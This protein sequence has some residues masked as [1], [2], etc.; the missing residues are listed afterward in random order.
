M[1]EALHDSLSTTLHP[2]APHYIPGFLPDSAGHDPLMTA[3]SVGLVVAFLGIGTLYFRLH[4]LP[5]HMAHGSSPSQ[6]QVVS[7]LALLAL[8]THNNI[9]WVA[10]LLLAA[11]KLPDLLGPLER[12]ASAVEQITGKDQEPQLAQGEPLATRDT[13]EPSEDPGETEEARN[14]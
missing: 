2:M 12:I 8:F 13:L 10:A 7:I 5:E 3:M 1:S 14:A 11:I 4:S 9:F 6:L